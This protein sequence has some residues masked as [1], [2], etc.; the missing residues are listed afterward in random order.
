MTPVTRR[1]RLFRKNSAGENRAIAIGMKTRLRRKC[2]F[3]DLVSFEN[4]QSPAMG[5][6]IQ[7][8]RL[9]TPR[10]TSKK[11]AAS[12]STGLLPRPRG[13]IS[14]PASVSAP[15]RRPRVGAPEDKGSHHPDDVHE[16]DVQDH[17][18]RRRRAHADRS[19]GRRVAVVAADEHDRRG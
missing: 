9:P 19:T 8:T 1:Y 17:R 7:S 13:A 2:M 11:V 4:P 10:R 5:T 14:T 15:D 18:L 12:R 16:H 3:H 6:P